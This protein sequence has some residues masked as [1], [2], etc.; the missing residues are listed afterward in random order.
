MRPHRK[1]RRSL[2]LLTIN[3]AAAFLLPSVAFG[4]QSAEQP[5]E[6]APTETPAPK[7]EKKKEKS[8]WDQIKPSTVWYLNYAAGEES[9]ETVNR[10]HVGRGYVT[11][12]YKPV[13]WFEPRVTLDTHQDDTGDWKVRLKY[14]YGKFKIPFESAVLTEPNLEV[15]I[16][17][18]PW[19]DYEE[20]IN[21]YRAEGTMFIE[22]NKILNSADLGF[23]VGGLLGRKLSKQYRK[24]V[25][26]KYPGKLGSFAVGVYNGGGYHATE[27]NDSK[28]FQARAS[29][30]PL[31]LL[32]IPHWQVSYLHIN[33]YGNTAQEPDW[34]LHN[35]M[36]SVE[37]Q[38]FVLTAQ[39]GF[40][41]GNQKGNKVDDAGTAYDWFG[42]SF[43]GEV[44]LP[45]IQSSLIGRVDRFDWKTDGGPSPT[46][47]VIA[48][49]V[50]HFL[51]HNFLLASIDHVT[52]D[53][54]GLVVDRQA[55][56]TL[57]IKYPTH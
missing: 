47:R 31:G 55:K 32:D 2:E 17:H 14:L 46:T 48:G 9:G 22:R 27:A 34:K 25:S 29:L 43:F 16:A 45:W 33:G 52:Y 23:T 35:F 41:E 11:I 56:L 21:N 28:V 13:K 10:F 44:K 24:K 57:Q 12:K 1:G 5:A 53:D 3:L 37:H 19:F 6:P 18:T 7:N 20:H 30:R 42:F 4:D 39:I 8:F 36:T 15:G 26:P 54:P 38:Y 49:H 51:P 50:F 40:G